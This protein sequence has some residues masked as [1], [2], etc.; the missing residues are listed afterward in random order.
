MVPAVHF[1]NFPL[2][3]PTIYTHH[4]YTHTQTPQKC[5]QTYAKDHTRAEGW[6]LLDLMMDSFHTVEKAAHRLRKKSPTAN[7]LLSYYWAGTTLPVRMTTGPTAPSK[8]REKIQ[9]FLC[10][11]C[12]LTLHNY[13]RP[14]HHYA[15][16]TKTQTY[17]YRASERAHADTGITALNSK[18]A[19]TQ[20]TRSKLRRKKQTRLPK[21]IKKP[22]YQRQIKNFLPLRG[23]KGRKQRRRKRD[24]GKEYRRIASC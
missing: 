13:Y 23:I 15:I 14:Q 11:K 17:T 24:E 2:H 10:S 4:I 20:H 19:D 7:V 22:L 5:M 21:L 8:R 18:L 12:S 1:V 16:H 6:R 9:K 3:R